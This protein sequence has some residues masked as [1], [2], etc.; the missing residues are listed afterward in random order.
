[1]EEGFDYKSYILEHFHYENGKL[2]RDDRR[3][4]EGSYD[5]DGYL[6]IKVK[7]RQLKAHRIVWLLNT[8]DWPSG[9]IDHINRV[10]DDNRFENLRVADRSLQVSNR[11]RYPDPETGTVG[12]HVDHST[13]G[14]KAVYS[15]YKYGK[16]YRFRS[17]DEAKD[18]IERV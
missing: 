5:K 15:F 4:S 3:N 12:I 2:H 9:E 10:R 8:G 13:A 6:I 7:K 11:T 14:L 1:M 17:L 16:T 18:A